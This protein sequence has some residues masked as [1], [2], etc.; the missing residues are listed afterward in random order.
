M[1]RR[2]VLLVAGEASGD[3]HGAGLVR[4]LR[5]GGLDADFYG[6]G[7]PAMAEAGVA[8]RHH[9]RELAVVGLTEALAR[10][11]RAVALWRDLTRELRRAPPDLFVPIDAPELNL[12]LA[13][14]AAG[15][16]VP[17]VY[18]VAPQLWAWRASR[19]RA[20]RRSVR[21]LL[22]L[23]PFEPDWFSARGVPT[24]YVGHPLIDALDALRPDPGLP[25]RLGLGENEPFGLLLPGSR[26]GEIARHLPVLAA[27]AARTPALRWVVRRAP[28]VEPAAYRRRAGDASRIALSDE[29][30]LSLAAAARIVVAASGTASFEA[31]LTGTPLI[32]VYRVSAITW[33]LAR[34]LVRVP[35]VSM[36]NLT[37]GRAIV[38]ELLQGD[39][40]PERLAA[41]IAALLADP[42]RAARMRADLASLRARFDTRGAYARAAERVRHHLETPAGATP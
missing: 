28:E 37:A 39:F 11:P 33:A 23:F 12:R 21:E 27:A 1:G 20:L 38:P 40:T 9:F 36:A 14:A 41:E 25:A 15:R 31:A 10:L 35:W 7:G 3:A 13:S 29:P 26:P 32:V 2:R 42:E 8:L 19:V 16:G 17:V 6:V 5:A 30:L 24:T 22:V 4:A 34:R 18:F